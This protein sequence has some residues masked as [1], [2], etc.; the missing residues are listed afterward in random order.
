MYRYAQ[1]IA[2]K[3]KLIEHYNKIQEKQ[4]RD[5]PQ[6]SEGTYKIVEEK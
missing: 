2:K 4:M 3:E 5:R 1:S 6:L